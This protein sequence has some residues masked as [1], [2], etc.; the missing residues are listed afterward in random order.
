MGRITR[1]TSR[2]ID[3]TLGGQNAGRGW[4]KMM[5]LFLALGLAL[6]VVSCIGDRADAATED[7][8]VQCDQK[9]TWS[10]SATFAPDNAQSVIAWAY[11]QVAA[12]TGTT[13]SPSIKADIDWEWQNSLSGGNYLPGETYEDSSLMS[14]R[15]YWVHALDGDVLDPA[16]ATVK[17]QVLRFVV[18]D[19]GVKG[20]TSTA[21]GLSAK[22]RAALKEICQAQA[23]PAVSDKDNKPPGDT[24]EDKADKPTGDNAAKDSKG[25]LVG[26]TP[27]PGGNNGLWVLLL[28]LA[29]LFIYAVAG[30][31]VLTLIQR[32]KGRDDDAH[33]DDTSSS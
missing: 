30:E 18:E 10:L 2:G 3:R 24:E 6:G 8:R 15:V 29:P 23:Q 20:A 31:K 7:P 21:N 25:N 11:Q 22:D 33:N 9:I 26:G 16:P 1:S 5:K 4:F 13:A 12:P 14:D 27:P 19:F 28:L 32:N 17:Q